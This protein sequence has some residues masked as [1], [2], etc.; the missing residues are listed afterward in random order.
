MIN[1]IVSIVFFLVFLYIYWHEFPY[2]SLS[3]AGFITTIIVWGIYF[4]YNKVRA[5]KIPVLIPI[6]IS[7]VIIF[8]GV[9]GNIS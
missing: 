6:I 2:D 7:V 5:D 1:N 3:G 9:L 4:V 8:F